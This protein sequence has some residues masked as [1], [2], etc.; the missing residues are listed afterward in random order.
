MNVCRYSPPAMNDVPS[1]PSNLTLFHEWMT[2]LAH[3]CLCPLERGKPRHHSPHEPGTLRRYPSNPFSLP[4]LC[5]ARVTSP[6]C[7]A[8]CH[9]RARNILIF[10]L[11]SAVRFCVYCIAFR[12]YKSPRGLNSSKPARYDGRFFVY[13]VKR[14]SGAYRTVYGRWVYTL[15]Y[16]LCL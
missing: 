3:S 14:T 6:I 11:S 5:C 16:E 13:K 1:V 8:A 10:R 9:R 12:M 2:A 4:V 15:S 7:H